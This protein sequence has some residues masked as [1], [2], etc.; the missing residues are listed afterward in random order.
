MQCGVPSRPR[1]GTSS[2][3]SLRDSLGVIWSLEGTWRGRRG[4]IIGKAKETIMW[5]AWSSCYVCMSS[6]PHRLP[7][8]YPLGNGRSCQWQGPPHS[9]EW[10]GQR[11][12]TQWSQST[13]CS[14]T[15]PYHLQ[16]PVWVGALSCNDWLVLHIMDKWWGWNHA[17]TEAWMIMIHCIVAQCMLCLV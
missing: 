6:P 9:Q 12:T 8:A 17:I 7:T 1:A 10:T 16:N 2:K 15:S 5:S 11:R 4:R 13:W 14:P 3:N